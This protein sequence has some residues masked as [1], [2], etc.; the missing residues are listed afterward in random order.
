M[1]YI[2]IFVVEIHTVKYL[3]LTLDLGEQPG[4]TYGNVLFDIET[5]ISSAAPM[6]SITYLHVNTVILFCKYSNN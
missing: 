4:L 2:A 5:F 6:K 1:L 3:C